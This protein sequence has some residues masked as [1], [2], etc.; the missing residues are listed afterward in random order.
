MYIKKSFIVKQI[1]D[2][3]NF[4]IKEIFRKFYLLLKIFFKFP[5]YIIAI[6]PSIL[7]RLISPIIIIR[8]GR[9]PSIN[10]GDFATTTA[11]YY[12]KKIMKKNLTKKSFLT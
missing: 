7:I 2:I 8:L 1:L 12:C 6:I 11:M 5:I 4:G 3:K 10:F 9:I